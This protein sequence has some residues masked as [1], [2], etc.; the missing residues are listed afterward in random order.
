L[1]SLFL[2]LILAAAETTKIQRRK[3]LSTIPLRTPH[4]TESTN[5][6]SL[7]LKKIDSM[8]LNQPNY[9]VRLYKEMAQANPYN[10]SIIHD[11]IVAE[12]IEINIKES[13]ITTAAD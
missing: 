7:H 6:S 13:T 8:S 4:S 11:Y 5:D 9:I 1:V 10:A 2:I 3:I 12:Q